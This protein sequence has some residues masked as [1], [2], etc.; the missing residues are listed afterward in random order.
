MIEE[1]YFK[2]AIYFCGLENNFK[3]INQLK[4]QIKQFKKFCNETFKEY[5][6]RLKD[7][8]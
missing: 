6:R 1:A 5:N 4:P 3:H 2:L 8:D 7:I